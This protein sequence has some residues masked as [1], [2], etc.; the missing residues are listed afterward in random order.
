MTALLEYINLQK[1]RGLAPRGGGTSAPVAP[2]VLR[3]WSSEQRLHHI[4]MITLKAAFK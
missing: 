3:L 1:W 2:L 4:D